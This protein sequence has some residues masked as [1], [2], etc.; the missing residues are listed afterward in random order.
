MLDVVAQ[1]ETCATATATVSVLPVLIL[2]ESAEIHKGA[3]RFLE[4]LYLL[5]KN[6][7][8]CLEFVD[9]TVLIDEFNFHLL[10][11]DL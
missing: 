4:S 3:R 5:S 6:I 1:A 7:L 10:E 11:F 2:S 9:F 8:R